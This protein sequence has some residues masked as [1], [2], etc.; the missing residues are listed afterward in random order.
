MTYQLGE[1]VILQ[2]LMG[3]DL[4][5]PVRVQVTDHCLHERGRLFQYEV[6]VDA[7]SRDT[8][9]EVKDL[10]CWVKADWLAPAHIVIQE[11]PETPWD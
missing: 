8:G 6:T 4:D 3:E 1:E 9:R 5:P 7:K 10:R 11:T 2:R